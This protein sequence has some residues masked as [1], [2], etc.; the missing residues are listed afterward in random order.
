MSSGVQNIKRHIDE[1][2]KWFLEQSRFAVIQGEQEE[3]GK[4]Q[5]MEGRGSHLESPSLGEGYIK[6]I[7][8]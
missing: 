7:L 1:E 4:R 6:K 8:V 5:T 3:R 2:K